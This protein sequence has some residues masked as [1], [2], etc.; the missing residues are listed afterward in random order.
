MKDYL[1]LLPDPEDKEKS[2]LSPEVVMQNLKHSFDARYSGRI[3]SEVV[4]TSR[5][6]SNGW[7]VLCFTFYLI[8]HNHNGYAYRLF[9]A[10]CVNVDGSY[11]VL[12]KSHYGPP[13]DYGEISDEALFDSTIREKILKDQRT[14]NVILSLY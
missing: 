10:E 7:E 8:F 14:R 3:S 5:L 2:K 11:P 12:L 9:E 6:N 13:V 1:D 4:S